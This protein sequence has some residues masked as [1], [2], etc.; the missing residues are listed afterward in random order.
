MA[1]ITCINAIQIVKW[2]IT[3]YLQNIFQH[4]NYFYCLISVSVSVGL[5][6]RSQDFQRKKEEEEAAGAWCGF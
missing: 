1:E 5:E 4:R 3:E 6:I 2:T